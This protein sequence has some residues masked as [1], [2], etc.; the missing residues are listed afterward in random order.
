MVVHEAKLSTS[1]GR[2]AV[3]ER[4]ARPFINAVPIHQMIRSVFTFFRSELASTP[5]QQQNN[6]NNTVKQLADQSCAYQLKT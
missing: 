5:H 2:L 6:V 4:G 3:G 1:D